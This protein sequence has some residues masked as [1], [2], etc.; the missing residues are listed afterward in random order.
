MPGVHV[1]GQCCVI[2]HVDGHRVMLPHVRAQPRVCITRVG[3]RDGSICIRYVFILLWA[4]CLPTVPW[5]H[6]Q[7]L[8]R[9]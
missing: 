7:L 2:D 6:E 8:L 9:N 3:L 4:S 5:W 1:R